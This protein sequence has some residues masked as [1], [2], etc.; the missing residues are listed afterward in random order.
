MQETLGDGKRIRA[1]KP[2]M[3]NQ[4]TP[5]YCLVTILKLFTPFLQRYFFGIQ[6]S[7]QSA[8]VAG[9][10][11]EVVRCSGTLVPSFISWRRIEL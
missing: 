8:K 4:N 5:S 2:F 7:N 11:Q 6:S 1:M 9:D 10:L 3:Y